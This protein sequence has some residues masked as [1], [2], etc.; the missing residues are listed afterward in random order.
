MRVYGHGGDIYSREILVDFSVNISP[1]GM[2]DTVKDAL[3]RHLEDYESYPDPF[4]RQL[5]AGLASK[6]GVKVGHILCGNG[7]SDLIYRLCLTQRPQRVLVTAPSFSDYE[8][9]ARQA[10]AQVFHHPLK[11]EDGFA[12]TDKIL[13]GI[14]PGLDMLFLCNPN[15]PT[16]RL[17]PH[18]LLLAILD[19]CRDLGVILI[20]DECF[21]P[22]TRARSL[23]SALIDYPNLLVLKAF[24][25]TFA[26][27][28]IRLGY[29]LTSNRNLLESCAGFGQDWSVSAVAQ[30]AGLA[31]LECKDW[32][33]RLASFMEAE[34]PRLAS[35]LE[36]LGIQVFPSQANFLLVKSQ[37]ALDSLLLEEKILIRSCDNFP[38][39][40]PDFYRMAVKRPDQNQVLLTAL[41]KRLKP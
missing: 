6:E 10:G 36:A 32:E 11:E 23:V 38:G 18:D 33:S 9:A 13:D 34:R 16:G 37:V 30:R 25:K 5:V 12:L 28:G 17:I 19:R 2:P 41:A 22:F 35:G 14:H 31:A 8:R 26:L 1:F 15:N 24:T 29:M 3:V 4:C 27:A 39:L 40:G 20:A 7:A 21:L